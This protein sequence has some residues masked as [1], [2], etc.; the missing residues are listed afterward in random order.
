MKKILIITI[1]FNLIMLNSAISDKSYA[2]GFSSISC[3]S[4]VGMDYNYISYPLCDGERINS[5][6]IDPLGKDFRS[7]N[8]WNAEQQAWQTSN[9]IPFFGNIWLN[10]FPVEQG[11]SYLI[12]SIQHNFKFVTTGRVFGID[13]YILLMPKKS[14]GNNFIMHPIEKINLSNASD[15]GNDI[16]VCS[17][18]SKW[19]ATS[20]AFN[21]CDYN[22]VDDIWTNDFISK[23][24]IPIVVS[25]TE[26]IIW[27]SIVS[28]DFVRIDSKANLSIN[29]PKVIYYRVINALKKDYNLDTKKDKI[30][31]KAWIV[32]REKDILT[33]KSFDCGF[34]T[35]NDTLST[36]YFNIGNF[37]NP[38]HPDDIIAVEVKVKDDNDPNIIS[39]GE[40]DYTLEENADP[41]F[42]GF[43][44]YLKGSGEPIVVGDPTSINDN[45]P[46]VTALYQNYPNP[47]N[48]MTTIKFSLK[49]EG[50]V[51]LNVYNYTGQLVKTLLNGQIES[52][53]HTIEFNASQ[54]SSG[55]YYYTLK[56]DTKKFTKKM[57]MIK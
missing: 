21:S 50:K 19:N 51:S 9:F 3:T 5:N 4:Y 33:E 17:Q 26:D 30:K 31:F 24:G 10:T 35:L 37:E 22:A 20:Q 23:I 12:S 55:V 57:L 38:W 28:K 25:V 34:I 11:V 47:F 44:E 7:I 48:P 1:V 40:G 54:L 15:I 13:P 53:Y 2:V 52:G 6:D 18:V 39:K 45:I 29:Y 49:D 16:A 43:E 32:D 56:I 46:T 36:I 41:V 8:K 27:P 14:N 42:I